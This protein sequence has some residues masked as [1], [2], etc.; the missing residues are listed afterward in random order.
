VTRSRVAAAA[1]AL[2]IAWAARSTSHA[3]RAAQT[4]D[5][6][7]DRVG[8]VVSRWSP[9]TMD[10][11]QI[12]T[13]R[14][15]AALVVMPDGTTLL[16]DAGAA[17]TPP[18]DARPNGARS[19]AAWIA[20]YID[21]VLPASA[22]RRLDYALLTHFHADHM[23]QISD[24]SPSSRK[25]DYRLSGIT[26]VAESMPIMRI[27]DRGWPD[28]AYPSPIADA[29]V[30]NYR[31]FLEQ[32]TGDRSMIAERIR[33]GRADQLVPRTNPGGYPSFEIR[34]VA[35]N[36]EIWTG[37][38]TATMTRFPKFATPDPDIPWENISSIGL[39]IR[40]GR[41]DFFTGGDA[42]GMADPGLPAWMDV[43]TP[44]ARAIGPTD[45]HVVNMHGSI[46][47]ENPFFL[48]T[49][50]S[51]VIILPSWSATH[52]SADVLKRVMAP[53]AYPG[54]RDIFATVLRDPTRAAMGARAD[55]IRGIGHI[56]V[57]VASGGAS[58]RVVVVDDSTDALTVKAVHGP[59]ASD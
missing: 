52:P 41:F 32:R 58:Y 38:G 26:E 34:A 40:Y 12:S 22:P 54:P 19:A 10:I 35:A 39:R 21:R 59:Y 11:H 47:V 4:A 5:D 57:R 17:A 1:G 44:I 20:H 23:G 28:Y 25:G 3:S 14:G 53:R 2:L 46:T 48:T 43:E 9:G 56:A 42:Y 15:N 8:Q 24:A 30:R 33:V 49:L 31:R 7:A 18:A 36:G 6:G 45:V 50:R 13:G 29:T 27:V 37:R 16:V 51:R 55:Q